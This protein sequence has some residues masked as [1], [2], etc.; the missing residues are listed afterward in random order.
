MLSDRIALSLVEKNLLLGILAFAAIWIAWLFIGV[1]GAIR[2]RFDLLEKIGKEYFPG[3]K[4]MGKESYR[5][6]YKGF[7]YPGKASWAKSRWFWFIVPFTGLVANLW[8]VLRV[9]CS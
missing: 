7:Y 4:S 6:T 3:I 5:N 2:L 1:A 8:L 9:N